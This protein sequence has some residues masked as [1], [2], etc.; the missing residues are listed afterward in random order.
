MV[1]ARR[2]PAH[3]LIGARV[4]AAACSALWLLLAARWLPQDQ[5]GD[6]ALLLALGVI[7]VACSDLGY[8]VSLPASIRRAPGSAN[9]QLRTALA[10]RAVA[11]C[12]AGLSVIG[13]YW[14]ASADPSIGASTA[15]A[16]SVLST[17]VHTACAAGMR[18]ENHVVPE[19]LAE[20]LSRVA[21]LAAGSVG[22]ALG[23]G[24]LFAAVLYA[25]ADVVVAVALVFAARRRFG[26]RREPAARASGRAALAIGLP[27]GTAYWRIDVWLI[28]VMAGPKEVALYGAAYRLLDGLLLPPSATGSLIPGEVATAERGNEWRAMRQLALLGGA[29]ATIPAVVVMI[30]SERTLEVLF[31][32]QY[33]EG[34]AALFAL[35]VAAGPSALVIAATQ[36]VGVVRPS[37]LP[38]LMAGALVANVTLNLWLIPIHGATGAAWSTVVCQVALGVALV[39]QLASRAGAR[40]V[41]VPVVGGARRSEPH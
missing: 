20:L 35:M 27:L 39:V 1:L 8:S 14:I 6:L 28:G 2:R 15:I 41:D 21:I 25:L 32:P 29:L 16:V 13:G 40:Q 38:A 33:G 34:S 31:G 23:R 24:L 26:S 37:V 18:G 9:G 11:G 12:I 4:A 30:T 36:A 3:V 7:A 19:S 17:A 10:H 22:L 5:F